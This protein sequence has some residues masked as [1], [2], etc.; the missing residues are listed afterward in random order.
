MNSL[1]DLAAHKQCWPLLAE[2]IRSGQVP[3]DRMADLE[4]DFPEF[5]KSLQSDVK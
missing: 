3:E 5:W 4:R 1:Y 2:L